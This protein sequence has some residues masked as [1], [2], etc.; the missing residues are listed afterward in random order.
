MTPLKNRVRRYGVAAAL[1]MSI[2]AVALSQVAYPQGISMTSATPTPATEEG[3]PFAKLAHRPGKPIPLPWKIAIVFGAIAVASLT[4]WISMRV[5][6]SANLF[7][8][9]YHFPPAAIAALRLGAMR[10]GGHMA[11]TNFGDR[12]GPSSGKDP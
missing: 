10:S 11:T 6:R 8:R 1:L 5:W 9:E 3:N 2:L 12:D 7:D 4:L